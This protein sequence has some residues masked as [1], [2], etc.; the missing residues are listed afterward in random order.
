MEPISPMLEARSRYV[1]LIVEKDVESALPALSALSGHN[2]LV[3][4]CLEDAVDTLC[5]EKRKP[6]FVLS[7]PSFPGSAGMKP[8]GNAAFLREAASGAGVPMLFVAGKTARAW[9]EAFDSL[10]ARAAKGI[11]GPLRLCALP[12]LVEYRSVDRCQRLCPKRPNC[13]Y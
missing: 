4:T 10:Q 6:D 1:V 2:I 12:R 9:R 3:A 13:L 7:A 8:E 5:S 11:R